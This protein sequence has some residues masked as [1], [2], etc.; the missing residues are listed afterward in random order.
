[1]VEHCFDIQ[2]QH[3]DS[4]KALSASVNSSAPTAPPMDVIE[5]EV[6]ATEGI[7]V[8]VIA[9]HNNGRAHIN[10]SAPPIDEAEQI[11]VA[12]NISKECDVAPKQPKKSKRSKVD[13]SDIIDLIMNSNFIDVNHIDPY[14]NFI[15]D[16]MYFESLISLLEQQTSKDEAVEDK[17]EE[18]KAAPALDIVTESKSSPAISK[19]D[20]QE[21]PATVD[22]S[23]DCKN[24]V[25]EDVAEAK[26]VPLPAEALA[27]ALPYA[28]TTPLAMVTATAV[29]CTMPE[30]P[31]SA[32]PTTW[33]SD[34]TSAGEA[35]SSN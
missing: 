2:Y 28:P 10:A 3:P 22:A 13:N 9:D 15:Y 17:V 26:N 6:I 25:V 24:Q 27:N 23:S 16:S 33:A 4:L 5:A 32:L 7:T 14:D 1:M 12:G 31:K 20:H 34:L 19:Q 30:A 11:E 8:A 21:Q 29:A 18:A 35:K